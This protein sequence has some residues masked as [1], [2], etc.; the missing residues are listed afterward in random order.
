M[1][2]CLTYVSTATRPDLANAVGILAR[3]MSRPGMEH[4]KGVK[5]VL[6]Y[7][8]GTINHGL[9][10]KANE[11]KQMIIGYSDADWGN[12]LD[13]RR[14]ISGY[15]FQIK[16]STVSWCS[17]RQ[18]GIAR[19][20]TEAEYVALSLATQEI[21]WLKK[22]L[23]DVNV[24]SEKSL[25]IYEDNQGAIELSKNA[26]FPNRTKHIDIAFHFIR[27]KV[28]NGSID[29]KYCPTDQMLADIMTKSLSKE[30]FIK[31]RELLGVSEI[32]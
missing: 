30:K 15:V 18:T 32:N 16:G 12:D 20:S 10:F 22:L 24:R 26:K 19:S 4:F 23:Q 1:I 11:E 25:V 9:V 28:G 14:S 29:A 31:F 8:K 27:E 13:T 6:R 7:T 17:K 5:R 21:V 3:Y 2:E